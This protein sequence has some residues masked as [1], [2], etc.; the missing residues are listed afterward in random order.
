MHL[1]VLFLRIAVSQ[2]V[3]PQR[4]APLSQSLGSAMTF[5][6]EFIEGVS[7]ELALSDCDREERREGFGDTA[8]GA[9]FSRLDCLSSPGIDTECDRCQPT[10]CDAEFTGDDLFGAEGEEK[11]DEHDLG[12]QDL[13]RAVHDSSDFFSQG[14]EP[15]LQTERLG[16]AVEPSERVTAGPGLTCG[17][18]W[19]AKT[20]S[21]EVPKFF[22][23]VDPFLRTVFCKDEPASASLKRPEPPIDLTL[24]GA[25][26]VW[27]VLR[28]P[29]R[30]ASVGICADVIKHVEVHDEKDKRVSIISNWTSLVCINLD[31]F[32]LSETLM[33]S[34]SRITHTD[35]EMSLTACFS[36]KATATLSKRFYA[37]NKFVNHCCRHGLQFF[38][39]REHVVFSYLQHLVESGSSAPSSGRSLLEAIR[40][41][42]G[43]IGLKGDLAS[44]GSSRVDGLA[45]EL[46]RQAGPIRQ[47][48]PLTVQ[49]VIAL[50][51]LVASSD[52][53]KD[54][55][56]FGGML[57]LLYACVRF[58]DGQRAINMIVDAEMASLDM[59]GFGGQGYLE[60]QVLG[61]KGARTEVLR[62]TFLPLVAPIYS[63]GSV[64]WFQSWLQA[65]EIMGLSTGGRLDK[66]F[67]CRFNSAG[68]QS[69]AWPQRKTQ[70]ARQD[71]P[72]KGVAWL[73][74]L[75]QAE[76]ENLLQFQHGSWMHQQCVE[77]WQCGQVQSWDASVH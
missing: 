76:A 60:L 18:E 2:R 55:V 10:E 26:T 38:P 29:K 48:E 1:S 36:R 31:A 7:E 35:V 53:M 8:D 58:S 41:A 44:L 50:E 3:S 56:V 6:F 15:E 24:G 42:G 9:G 22:W 5:P 67:L 64:Q 45:V 14:V 63:L 75:E 65:R 20:L 13:W 25:D 61:H 37:L 30:V 43:V 66:P 77:G 16:V 33:A 73:Q 28:R 59:G 49:Q 19:C 69:W 23:E 46:A 74:W 34:G 27:D 17:P 51:R 4:T 11:G 32:S 39:V 21:A 54:R 52:D 62:R 70:Q 68:E 72:S 57:V 12:L 47:A 71:E 40:F